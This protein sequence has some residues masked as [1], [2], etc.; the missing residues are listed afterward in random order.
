[1]SSPIKLPRSAKNRL[2]RKNGDGPP[3][4]A[5]EFKVKDLTLADWGRKAIDIAEH[6]M[7]GL[8]SIRRQTFR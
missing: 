5:H 8:M 7:P 2:N 1:M 6:E 3:D 4:T